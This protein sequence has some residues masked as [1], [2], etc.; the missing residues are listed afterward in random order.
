MKCKFCGT[1]N[2]EEAIFC[3]SCGKQVNSNTRKIENYDALIR[4]ANKIV[5]EFD[6][7]PLMPRGDLSIDFIRDVFNFNPLFV[8]DDLKKAV[9]DMLWQ[10]TNYKY[11]EKELLPILEETYGKHENKHKERILNILINNYKNDINTL[12][13]KHWS[14]MRL[15]PDETIIFYYAFSIFYISRDLN[16]NSGLLFARKALQALELFQCE[17]STTPFDGIGHTGKL[18]KLSEF[19][20]D[21]AIYDKLMQMIEKEIQKNSN[22]DYNQQLLKE[23]QEESSSKKGCYIA[24][25]VYDSYNCPQVWTLRRY[26]D[27]CLKKTWYGKVFVETYYLISPFLVR[28]FG[29]TNWFKKVWKIPLDHIVEKLQSS[30]FES[31]PYEDSGI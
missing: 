16:N 17:K 19:S 23:Q 13:F 11:D 2:N 20:A 18:L 3:L 21:K 4:H 14:Y 29:R 25:C 5:N 28:V 12:W 7:Y 24:T 31:T 27:L 26:R 8:L 30:G 1:I 15:R 22:E 9:M 10:E 6:L